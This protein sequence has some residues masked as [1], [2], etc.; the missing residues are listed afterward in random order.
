MNK[1]IL[2][3]KQTV[4]SLIAAS[5]LIAGSAYAGDVHMDGPDKP[6]MSTTQVKSEVKDKNKGKVIY[7]ERK[8]T[9][10][11]PNCHTV[12]MVTTTGEFRYIRYACGG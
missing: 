12:K 10:E 3:V 7:I 4:Q 8:A 2:S 11:H 6:H 1:K 9:S 5:F